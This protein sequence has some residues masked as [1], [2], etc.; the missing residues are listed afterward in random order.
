[1]KHFTPERY[2]RLGDLSDERAFLSAQ[3]EWEDANAA[4]RAQFSAVRR[5]LP[6]GLRELVTKVYLHD[7]E[8]VS[9]WQKD[10]SHFT[11]TLRPES[12]P[13]KLVV[14]G[15]A[16]VK[17]PVIERDV[18]PERVRSE[19]TS[20]LYDELN[21]EGG[22]KGDGKGKVVTHDVLLSNGWELRLRAKA[23]TVSQPVPVLVAGA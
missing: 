17:P 18:L 10:E 15:Y 4:Y 12:T 21:V 20:W 19:P 13:S 23:V 6:R 5:S 11:I 8:V 9:M 14:L 1:M 16:L 22:A 7:A 2:L 3:Q